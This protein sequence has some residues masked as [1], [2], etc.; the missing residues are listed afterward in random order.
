M[1]ANLTNLLFRGTYLLTAVAAVVGTIYC[2]LTES[3]G[4]LPLYYITLAHFALGIIVYIYDRRNRINISYAFL[5]FFTGGMVFSSAVFFKSAQLPLIFLGAKFIYVSTFLLFVP[6]VY[7]SSFFPF[8]KPRLT[9]MQKILVP[10]PGIILSVLTL[11][12]DLLIKDVAFRSWGREVVFGPL[13][14]VFAAYCAVYVG[15]TF[16]VLVYKQ[17]ISTAL[18]KIQISYIFLSFLIIGIPA[19]SAN[20]VFPGL[21]QNYRFIEP[22]LYFALP[23]SALV[24]YAIMKHRL[25]S[26]EV[27]IQ[28]STVYAVATV[29]IMALYALAVIISETYLRKIMGYTSLAVTALAALIIA[30]I[31]Q[32]LVKSFQNLTDRL[33]FRG[34][35][36]YQKTLRKISHEIAS[37]IKLEELT[38][39][40]ASSFI[41]TMMISEIS[42]L[43]LEREREHFRSV[44]LTIPRYK[45]IEIDVT[46][47][48]VSWLLANKDILVRE[49]IE[50]E[51]GR[52]GTP[53]LA[54]VR[55]AMERLG[56]SIWVPIISKDALIGIIALGN[57]LSGDIF[58]SEDLV[59]LTTLA[60]QTAVALDNARLYDE[61]LSM[62]NYSDE[63]LRSMT[64][65]VLT[66]DVRGRIITYNYMAERITGKRL[67]EVLG[68]TCE[69][70]WGVRGAITTA[71]DKTLKD[72][73][74]TNFETGV[75][76]PERGLV[77]VAFSSTL[78]RDGQGKKM[79]ALLSI[80]DLSEMKELEDKIRRAD[81]LTALATMAAGMAHEI[82]NPLSSMKV[83]A[84]L[85]P[86][87]ID[88]PEYRKKLGEILPREIDRIDRIVESLLGFARSTAPTFEKVRIEE[89]LEENVKYFSEKA[90]NA[91]VKIKR[92]YAELPEIEV[93]KG[94]LSQVF[95]NLILNAIQAMP[96]GGEL[97]VT[98]L[99]GKTID[100][101]LQNVK[102]KVS[103]TGHG[104]PEEM[105]KKLFDPFF[106]TKYGGTG[107]GLTIAHSVVDGHKGF[108]DVESRVGKGTTFTVTLPVSQGLV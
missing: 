56:I 66:T 1:P 90:E 82:K 97:A 2:L 39:F 33:F 88:D 61:V 98:T 107:L 32:P 3:I 31:Y 4:Y 89:I 47:P 92:S 14:P 99:P 72:R 51:I 24:A 35:Y 34:R 49:E 108:I 101:V 17:R 9:L 67:S 21:F 76:S 78:L 106:T 63:I 71:V 22:A 42:F 38:K 16:S 62:K 54:E 15:Y 55:D 95:S 7:F 105:Q 96:D 37:V 57:K 84:Q 80:Q 43:L 23:E 53:G 85:L 68:K 45:R 46:S 29:L 8:E 40:I 13:F 50:D 94:Q 30:V 75:A 25:M 73:P 74:L 18:Q 70:V 6:L 20:I 11:T 60:N 48:I 5:V 103:D 28:R 91:G 27:V 104:I 58:T 12:T 64:N 83:F 69:E 36:D 100:Q 87:K 10:V 65:G 79:G 26:I 19:F 93:D 86:L 102:V 81:K 77:P 52:Q 44:P 41:E 59:L